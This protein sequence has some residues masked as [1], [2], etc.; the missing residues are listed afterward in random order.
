M[1]TDTASEREDRV[2]LSTLQIERERERREMT[3]DATAERQSNRD[4]VKR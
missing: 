2:Q 3:G 1:M 4:A